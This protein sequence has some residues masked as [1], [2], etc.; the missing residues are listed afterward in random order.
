MATAAPPDRSLLTAWRVY[1]SDEFDASDRRAE[2]SADLLKYFASPSGFTL[3]T[4]L[5]RPPSG[6][7]SLAL[8]HAALVATCEAAD[9][10]AALDVAPSEA[11]LCLSIAAHA[12]ALVSLAGV[13][14]LPHLQPV[15]RGEKVCILLFN[16]AA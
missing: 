13:T 5:F 12:A 16:H 7:L 3:L 4:P 14:S 6:G 8:D 2:L 15:E 10:F 1:V 11:L 9:L